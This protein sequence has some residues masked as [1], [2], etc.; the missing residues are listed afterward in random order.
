MKRAFIILLFLMVGC[1]PKAPW[2]QVGGLH[3]M[4][5]QDFSVELPQ[6][7]MRVNQ[8]D[9]LF[10]TRDGFLL[11]YIRVIRLDIEQPLRYTKKKFSKSMLPQEVAEVILDNISSDQNVLD[12]NLLE[13]IPVK[14]SGISGFRAVYTY[15]NKDGLKIKGI[16]CGFITDKWFY[17]IHY[18]AAHRYYFDKDVK[19]FE[20]VL[21][22]FKLLKT[23]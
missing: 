11:Q 21:E 3:N 9:Y 13:N 12:F 4:E 7:W 22:S 10:I 18:S 19:T 14:I 17:G 16:Y 1:A 23:A 8:G 2:V 5:S 20:K 15:K 6:G